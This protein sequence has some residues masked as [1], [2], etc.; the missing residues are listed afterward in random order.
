MNRRFSSVLFRNK[1]E[2]ILGPNFQSILIKSGVS[3]RNSMTK[4]VAANRGV[5]RRGPSVDN[6]E[7]I[8]E[9][10]RE[11]YGIKLN[12]N[13][14]YVKD[15]DDSVEETSAVTEKRSSMYLRYQKLMR[16]NRVLKLR[17]RDLEEEIDSMKER[18]KA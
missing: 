10:L 14:F 15:E 6:Q 8:S 11:K 9:F 17:I 13:E 7:K 5:G 1:M 2:E 4:W 18:I 16:E 3:N 12:W